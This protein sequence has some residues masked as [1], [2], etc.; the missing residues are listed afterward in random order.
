M[1][2]KRKPHHK[3]G[4]SVGL[5]IKHKSNAETLKKAGEFF[6]PNGD[7]TREIQ[8]IIERKDG[9]YY[10]FQ[11]QRRFPI[12]WIDE[13]RSIPWKR[14]ASIVT[15]LFFLGIIPIVAAILNREDVKLVP[16]TTIPSSLNSSPTIISTYIPLGLP[17]NPITQNNQWSPIFREFQGIRMVLVPVGCFMM[18]ALDYQ[19][20]HQQCFEEPFWIGRTEITNAQYG[21]T[22]YFA[23]DNRP[24]D[25]VGW[26]DARDF[27]QRI[28]LRLPTEREWEYAARGPDNLAYPWGNSYISA[29]VVGMDTSNN[30][31]AD[32][33]SRWRG[34]SWVGALDM[35]GNV[36]E[37]V[38]SSI[39]QYPYDPNDGRED[40]NTYP[41]PRVQRGGAYFYGSG[42][43]RATYRD[44]YTPSYQ[45]TLPAGASPGGDLPDEYSGPRRN[46]FRCARDFYIGDIS[47]GGVPGMRTPEN[48]V[49]PS[50]TPSPV[51]TM[52]P[53]TEHLQVIQVN[54]NNN[55]QDTNLE[56]QQGD[57]VQIAVISGSW[58]SQKGE[59]PYTSGEGTAYICEQTEVA[60]DC[61]E[62]L[63]SAPSG[64]LIG[65]LGDRLF[66]IGRGVTF[67]AQQDGQLFLRMNDDIY[68]MNDNDG[69]L[70]VNI[71]VRD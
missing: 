43:L 71:T 17:G 50:Q 21:S 65:R 1:L 42:S 40:L 60:S 45:D 44:A 59:T 20:I 6:G 29:Y 48:T 49:I 5:N 2:F 64:A 15:T 51:P 14:L 22:G 68:G 8:G 7:Q 57:E 30:D 37:W 58:T 28:G 36:A 11:Q 41:N 67:V 62:P 24:R 55:W 34:V 10:V 23:G 70:T 12:H 66:L 26:Y 9:L 3:V 52:T 32:V 61:T 13:Q 33:G 19:P 63:P 35:S 38:S 31:T 54:A 56:V 27:C 18:G 39:G 53:T 4:E 46:G 69:S 47:G 16:P 25:Y